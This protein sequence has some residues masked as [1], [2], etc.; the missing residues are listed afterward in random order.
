M[1]KEFYEKV[2]K[3][4]DKRQKWFMWFLFHLLENY[5]T[6]RTDKVIELLYNHKNINN[7]LDVWCWRWLLLN[8]IIEIHPEIK[9][10][11]WIDI[12]DN[13]LLEAKKYFN[14]LWIDNNFYSMD[15]SSWINLDNNSYDLITCIAV[16]EHLF[17]PDYIV[18]EFNRIL[19]SWWI[20]I[21]QVPNI[22]V[23]QRRI[24]FLFWIRPRTSWDP[25]W[26]WWHIVYF[27]KKELVNLLIKNWFKISKVTW[28]W[29][30]ANL[31][32]WWVSLLSPDIIIKA[33]K[34]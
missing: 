13:N 31:R 21:V 34:I 1:N 10:V 28:S 4:Q 27:T 14:E 29:I 20:L 26:D 6:S 24:S 3:V 11:N 9:T 32:N 15:I 25:G 16:L 5:N 17:D 22:V 18:K 7:I 33:E 8:K 2:S 30:F 19:K 23:L 12:S